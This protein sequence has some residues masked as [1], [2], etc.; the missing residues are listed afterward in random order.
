MRFPPNKRSSILARATGLLAL[1]GALL[2]VKAEDDPCK[3]LYDFLKTSKN[4]GSLPFPAKM[5]YDCQKAVPIDQKFAQQTADQLLGYH[6]MVSYQ[7]Y[8]KAPPLAQLELKPHDG[9][10]EIKKIQEK[11]KK[12]EYKYTY[13]FSLDVYRVFNKYQDGHTGLIPALLY[14]VLYM[15]NTPIV[16]FADTITG[17]P[18]VWS[19]TGENGD[20]LH[21][22]IEKINDVTVKDYLNKI[23]S[24]T[25]EWFGFADPDTR[26]NMFMSQLPITNKDEGLGYFQFRGMYPGEESFTI[27]Y[28]DGTTQKVEWKAMFQQPDEPPLLSSAAH[29]GKSLWWNDEEYGQ[30]VRKFTPEEIKLFEE[31][32]GIATTTKKTAHAKTGSSGSGVDHVKTGST[33]HH[34]G[35]AQPNHADGWK[36]RKVRRDTVGT[37]ARF[38]R[39]SAAGLPVNLFKRLPRSNGISKRWSIKQLTHAVGAAPG[40]NNNENDDEED[41]EDEEDEDD[42][43]DGG[44]KEKEKEYEEDEYDETP[45]QDPKST[46]GYPPSLRT[47]EDN[48]LAWYD[49]D[50]QTAVLDITGFGVASTADD[51]ENV[52]DY[53][54]EY[55]K[56]TG[57]K[58]LI[59]DLTNN[60]GG[61]TYLPFDFV[62]TFFPKNPIFESVNQR[63]TKPNVAAFAFQNIEYFWDINGKD[64]K[65][66]EDILGPVTKDGDQ[67]TNFYK[68]DHI[69]GGKQIGLDWNKDAA[70][71]F[72]KDNIIVISN[73]VCGSSCAA[74]L[75]AMS[76][77]GV[78]NYA[79]GGRPNGKKEMQ[80]SGGIKG[81]V[82]GYFED[83][84]MMKQYLLSKDDTKSLASVFPDPLRLV[85]MG[86][87]N[88]ENQ[89]RSGK[90]NGYPLQFVYDPACKRVQFTKDMLNSPKAVWE[91]AKGLGWDKDG[92]KIA[93][94]IEHKTG[95]VV[96]GSIGE[97]HESLRGGDGTPRLPV[98]G[99]KRPWRA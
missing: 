22:E 83:Y 59:I 74:F 5:A 9:V 40:N 65:S 88:Y 1:S 68:Y 25:D 15:H 73:G 16:S 32:W 17:E 52:L 66:F 72:D 19:L 28:K 56:K 53:G 96:T 61:T 84:N 95:T 99:E 97:K 62:R 77:Q 21:K 90:E 12:G 50:G 4:D 41:E 3:K 98:P 63:Y 58:R 55:L 23:L 39:R 85:A 78:R 43:V 70:Q 11:V 71:P 7:V 30:M 93:C 34:I 94:E 13:D 67:F 44:D 6:E 80:A 8:H 26:W 60:V 37:I 27:K 81:G 35:S 46:T 38:G 82:I 42:K 49:L 33:K 24:E 69:Q 51:Y 47:S 87:I 54:V 48:Y 89:F 91:A 86:S 10:A 92:K 18:K 36:H 45:G 75:E 76:A 2:T 20:K 64:F 14:K 29:W 79:F 31:Q 57:H